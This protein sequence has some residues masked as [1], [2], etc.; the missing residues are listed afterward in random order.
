MTHAS[1]H[2]SI[3]LPGL[4]G[5]LP[6]LG[7]V[8]S[9]TWPELRTLDAVL[10]RADY[11]ET[12]RVGGTASGVEATLFALFGVPFESGVDLPVAALTRLHD[13]GTADTEAWLRADPVYVQVDRDRAYVLAHTGLAL[14]TAEAEALGGALSEAFAELGWTLEVRQAHRWYLRAGPAGSATPKVVTTPLSRVLGRDMHTAL[15]QGEAARTW[16][17]YL[18]EAQ[19]VLHACALNDVREE[20][21]QLPVNSLWF[22]GG[23]RLPPVVP[24]RYSRV[25]GDDPL[26]RGLARHTGTPEA[27]LP[28]DVD[29]LLG[30]CGDAGNVLLVLDELH[31]AVLG[32]DVYDWLG[33]VSGFQNDWLVPLLAALR[34]GQL[35]GLTL[36]SDDGRQWRLSRRNW[37]RVWGRWWRRRRSLRA[38]VV[39]GVKAGGA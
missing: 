1:P 15:P 32:A 29:A 22:W 31:D 17:Q 37:G 6:A 19:M 36:I 8:A 21:G 30:V 27:A 38:L 3:Y 10:S 24:A 18:N 28:L 14:R 25:L 26:A 39:D 9:A 35:S 34:Q 23:G 4:C 11:V 13:G 33:A 2:L 12:Q 20:G 7:E 16:R 5:P